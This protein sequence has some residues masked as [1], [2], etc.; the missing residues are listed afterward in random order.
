MAYI[1]GSQLP[2]SMFRKNIG[3]IG[4]Y[5]KSMLLK[6]YKVI[7]SY[8]LIVIFISNQNICLIYW[9]LYLT[10]LYILIYLQI[11]NC[12]QHY[13]QIMRLWLHF[14]RHKNNFYFVFVEIF[15]K[16]VKRLRKNEQSNCPVNWVIT[17]GTPHSISYFTPS[18][19]FRHKTLNCE[20][21]LKYRC[22]VAVSYLEWIHIARS[23]A[24]LSVSLLI[25]TSMQLYDMEMLYEIPIYS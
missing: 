13:I 22:S 6:I 24:Y 11:M 8:L 19:Y 20:L 17:F 5:S 15:Y 9:Y 21:I 14:E 7:N 16:E 12:M 25:S 2:P 18:F 23:T 1:S 10:H 3:I 4:P